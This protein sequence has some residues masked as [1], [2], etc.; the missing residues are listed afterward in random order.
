MEVP[1]FTP[2]CSYGSTDSSQHVARKR[3]AQTAET[4]PT[5]AD[6]PGLIPEQLRLDRLPPKDAETGNHRLRLPLRAPAL[7]TP[8]RDAPPSPILS[9]LSPA[10]CRSRQL[11]ASA[12][13][14]S[15]TAPT[16]IDPPRSRVGSL[17]G[18]GGGA[19]GDVVVGRG[20]RGRRRGGHRQPAGEGQGAGP[21]EEGPGRSGGRDQ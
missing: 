2:E 9:S 1:S 16:R 5:P 11:H 3:I 20:R 19:A 7:T 6:A 4:L 15:C 13:P 17:A 10:A 21:A 18:L 12:G 8:C 14:P